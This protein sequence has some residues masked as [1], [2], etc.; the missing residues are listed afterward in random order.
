MLVKTL[1]VEPTVYDDVELV[2]T[3]LGEYT[4]LMA[5]S[6][7]NDVIV[8][9]YSFFAG[10]NQV[11]YSIIGK[12]CSVASYA[13]IN[14]TNHPTYDRIAQHHFTY[15]SELFGFGEDDAD[16]FERRKG[17]AVKVG[18]DVWV[19]HN[20]VIMPG[21]TIGNGAV[22]GAGAVVTKDV[23]PYSVVGGIPAKKIKMR[24]SDDLIE[25][26]ERSKWW[27]WEH[28]TIRERLPDFRDMEAFVRTY[29]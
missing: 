12:F 20:A 25:R 4:H 15:R 16:F 6:V 8:G 13:R 23:E 29:L 14:T 9:D 27:D 21:V 26:I 17:K 24:F 22:I 2:E 28:E 11:Y 19:G 3:T 5:H 1:G 10:Y 7:F 18:H